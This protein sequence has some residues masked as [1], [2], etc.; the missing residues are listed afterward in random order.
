MVQQEAAL[1]DDDHYSP[2]LGGLLQ[3]DGDADR[4]L[5]ALARE[6]NPLGRAGVSDD[7]SVVNML[8]DLVETLRKY[9]WVR[10][11]DPFYLSI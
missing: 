9:Y 5:E 3:V 2:D 7:S 1:D 8:G 6:S 10:P 4:F 11:V